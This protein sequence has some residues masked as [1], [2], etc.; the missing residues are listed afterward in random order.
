[1]A[2]NISNLVNEKE[3]RKILD[4][5]NLRPFSL[6]FTALFNCFATS[7]AFNSLSRVSHF[8]LTFL[9]PLIRLNLGF[10]ISMTLGRGPTSPI[11]DPALVI[12][13][14]QRQRIGQ[15]WKEKCGKITCRIGLSRQMLISNI[16]TFWSLSCS[17]FINGRRLDASSQF[18]TG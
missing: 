9:V 14:M 16:V 3:K 6:I 13:W 8:Y 18:S 17:F 1:M 5:G 2:K 11:V 12:R 10:P 4:L 15:A 7:T